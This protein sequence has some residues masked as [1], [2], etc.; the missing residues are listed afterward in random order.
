MPRERSLA[1]F[2]AVENDG[3]QAPQAA[4][5]GLGISESVSA[6][7]RAVSA[8]APDAQ[9]QTPVPVIAAVRALRAQRP[10]P[11]IHGMKL[12]LLSL[13]TRAQARKVNTVKR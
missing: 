8:I 2:D 7:I 3:A 12:W 6:L 11:I 10:V 9:K 5:Q 4:G 1:L 13:L